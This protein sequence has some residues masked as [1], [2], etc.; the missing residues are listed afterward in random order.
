MT[1]INVGIPPAELADR[2][3]IAEH[4]ELKRIPNLV[5]QGKFNMAGQ[6]AQFT[7]GTGH[8]K[9]FY[10]KLGYLRKRYE[11]LYNEC[12]RRGFAVSWFG[13]AWDGIDPCYLGDYRP[14]SDAVALVRARITER[15][16]SGTSRFR[17]GD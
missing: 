2:M 9:F 11:L 10:D 7:L 13:N 16:A 8:V 15:L 14:T 12:Q 17:M 1:R 5:R 4:R 3:L 6:P